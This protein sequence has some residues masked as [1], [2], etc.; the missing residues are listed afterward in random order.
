MFKNIFVKTLYEKR[1]G[2]LGWSVAMFAMTIFIVVLYPMFQDSFGAQLDQVPES[3]RAILGEAADYQKL[4]GFLE[5]Q[6]FAQM[7]FLTFIYGIIVSV[8]LLAGEE[9]KGTLQTLLVQPISRTKIYWQKFLA[10]AVILAIVSFALFLAVVIGALIIHEPLSYWATFQATCMQWLLSIALSALAFAVGGATGSRAIAG[11]IAGV[12]TF[13]A[14]TVS[15]LADSVESLQAIN[16]VSLFKYIIGTK[17][18][19]N[20][21]IFSNLWPI[22]LFTLTALI[23][24]WYI[25]VKRSIYQQ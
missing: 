2:I 18:L 23:A 10:V 19:E 11:T 12:Y 3:M 16:N 1:W 21:I 25:F 22:A 20:G 14:Y 24:G 15:A 17:I 9:Y 8:A 13:G 7:V 4:S 6:V 5:L